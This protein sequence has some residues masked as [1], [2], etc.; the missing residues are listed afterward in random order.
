MHEINAFFMELYT[1]F[2]ERRIESVISKMTDNVKW[3]NG[4]NGGYVYGH[5]E[6]REYWT[7]QFHLISSKVI[8]LETNTEGELVK[9]KVHQVVHDLNGKLLADEVVYHYFYLENKKIVS[10]E[11]GEK[12][13]K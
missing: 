1:N 8:P 5:D 2:N 6:V 4:M 7:K 9:I 10:F 13:K 11:I 3:A 12:I